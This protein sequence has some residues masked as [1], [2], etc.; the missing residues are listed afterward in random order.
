MTDR[1]S[2]RLDLW[3]VSHQQERRR[4]DITAAS[5]KESSI[6]CLAPSAVNLRAPRA[7]CTGPGRWRA[8]PTAVALT[9]TSKKASIT[10]HHAR[11]HRLHEIREYETA[12]TNRSCRHP[13]K[14]I[15]QCMSHNRSGKSQSQQDTMYS[16]QLRNSMPH[17]RY[18]D[19]EIIEGL[20]ASPSAHILPV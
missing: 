18:L 13:W 4:T 6:A 11:T 10:S 1:V 2:C 17:S 14:R 15:Q 16:P 20:N 8:V 19:N 9:I 7:R 12:F 5:R 3:R